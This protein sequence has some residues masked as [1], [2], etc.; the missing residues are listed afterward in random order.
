MK[1]LVFVVLMILVFSMGIARGQGVEG[2]ETAEEETSEGDLFQIYL[3]PMIFY[4]YGSIYSRRGHFLD[5]KNFGDSGQENFG[6]RVGVLQDLEGVVPSLWGVGGDVSGDWGEWRVSVG[7]SERSRIW[8]GDADDLDRE[9]EVRI[10]EGYWRHN[11]GDSHTFM[12]GKI[13]LP[14]SGGLSFQPLDVLGRG[15]LDNIDDNFGELQGV[16][17]AIWGYSYGTGFVELVLAEESFWEWD[18]GRFQGSSLGS[19][20]E[21]TG[22]RDS[23][24]PYQYGIRWQ[25]NLG[26]VDTSIVLH[27]GSERGLGGGSSFFLGVSDSFSVRGEWFV[28]NGS[29]RPI[30]GRLVGKVDKDELVEQSPFDAWNSRSDLFFRGAV[31]MQWNP[32]WGDILQDI[33]V[34]YL[35]D[36]R[37]LSSEQWDD[38]LDMVERHK[39]YNYPDLS[40]PHQSELL[41]GLQAQ[42]DGNLNYDALTLLQGSGLV[43]QNYSFIQW[44]P[45]LTPWTPQINLL[46]SVED[47]SCRVGGNLLYSEFGGNFQY[48]ISLEANIGDEKTQFG[49]V[50]NDYKI[51]SGLWFYSG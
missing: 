35:Y 15:R 33:V 12:L 31:G 38:W 37:G 11:I 13:L 10:R 18:E 19:R 20:G 7:A 41:R 40:L 27:G 49:N 29:N 26:S 50:P 9:Q 23:A 48:R 34:E 24:T 16:L 44:T 43:R 25:G 17:G 5:K 2:E 22:Y 1:R 14:W 47:F 36:Q 32:Y 4:E 42:V 28:R 8:G 3:E 51:S 6:F 39:N 46:C 45:N 21:G 30:D